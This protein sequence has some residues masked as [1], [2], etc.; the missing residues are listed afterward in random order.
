V[1]CGV[2]W[3]ASCRRVFSYNIFVKRQL[4]CQPVAVVQYTF[5]HKQNTEQHNGTE[6]T[7][8][9]KNCLEEC[10]GAYVG[11]ILITPCFVKLQHL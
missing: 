4:G 11:F 6:N 7:E 3:Y 2:L 5:A 9:H 1:P 8:Q 10:E